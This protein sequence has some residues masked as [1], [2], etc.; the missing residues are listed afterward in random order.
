MMSHCTYHMLKMTCP[1]KSLFPGLGIICGMLYLHLG[2]RIFLFAVCVCVVAKMKWIYYLCDWQPH[3]VNGAGN[4]SGSLAAQNRS[5]LHMLSCA[6]II[7]DT[8]TCAELLMCEANH[9]KTIRNTWPQD[10]D[11]YICKKK[12]KTLSYWLLL[13][14]DKWSML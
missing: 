13:W 5:R 11:L 14:W 9:F 3:G 10:S 12:K 8:F 1:D 4:G 6:S 2:W 7:F